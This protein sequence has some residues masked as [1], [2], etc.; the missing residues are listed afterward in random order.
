MGRHQVDTIAGG[1]TRFIEK[2]VPEG[3]GPRMSWNGV[4]NAGRNS[5][6]GGADVFE[7]SCED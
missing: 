2:Q 3:H 4:L 1:R 5:E 6:V 7:A